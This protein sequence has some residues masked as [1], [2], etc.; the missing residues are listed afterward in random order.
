[1]SEHDNDH[2]SAAARLVAPAWGADGLVVA[3][4]AAPEQPEVHVTP[5]Q[6]NPRAVAVSSDGTRAYTAN[7]DAGTLSVVDLGPAVPAVLRSPSAGKNPCAVTAGLAGD[8]VC[9]ANW[10]DDQVA[11]FDKEGLSSPVT[12][13]VGKGP[14]A[15]AAAPGG[16]AQHVC[17]VNETDATVSLVDVGTS[18]SPSVTATVPV[19]GV[20]RAIAVAKGGRFAYVAS[21]GDGTANG[22]VTVLDVDAEGDP[23]GDPVSVGAEPRALALSA[24]G[25]RL[26][27]AAYGSASVSVASVNPTTGRIETPVSIPVEPHPVAVAFTPDGSLILAVG[28]TS[29]RLTAIRTDTLTPTTLDEPVGAVPAGV[30]PGPDGRFAYVSD[31]ASGTLVTVRTSPRKTVEVRTGA[32]SQPVNV[33]VAPD[34]SWAYAADS[35]SGNVAVLDLGQLQPGTPVPLGGAHKPWDVA[36]APDRT[37]ACATSPGT[38]ALLVLTPAQGE[39][40][41][42]GGAVTVKAIALAPNA[43]PHGVAI[44]PDGHYAVTAD[45]GTATVSLVDPKGGKYTIEAGVVGC[46]QPTGA[47]LSKDGTTLY[48]SDFA[49][50]S[51]NGQ[52]A[53]LTRTSPGT[54]QQ[55]TPIDSVT[56][57][58][59]GPHELGLS[60]DGLR[61]CVA[62]YQ[63][64]TVSVLQRATTGDRWAFHMTVDKPAMFHPYG[65]ALTPDGRTLYVSNAA[66]NNATVEAFDISGNP[67]THQRTIT[68]ENGDSIPPGLALSPDGQYLYAA[69]SKAWLS[70]DAPLGMVYGIRLSGGG[71]AMTPVAASPA[72][73]HVDRPNGI[74]CPDNQTLYVVNQGRRETPVRDAF[75]AVITLDASRLKVQKVEQQALDKD[76]TP[77]SIAI[78]RDDGT[79]CIANATSG[80]VTVFTSNV[81]PVKVGEPATSRPWDVA[82]SDD[83]V[84]A[85]ISD[86]KAATVHCLRLAD[87]EV[88]RVPVRADPMGVA[89]APGGARAYVANHVDNSITVI[90][91]NG[92]QGRPEETATWKHELITKPESVS[93][94]ADGTWLFVTTENSGAVLMLDATTGTPRFTVPAGRALAAGAP[95]PRAATPLV[96]L[97]DTAGAAVSVVNT[98]ALGR[99][100]GTEAALDLRQ[101]VV[102]PAD[103]KGADR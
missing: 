13:D 34:G 24:E 98:T 86:R 41:T 19:P 11:V 84:Y 94:S 99:V 102:V 10:A 83:G 5:V 7:H 9:V 38:A 64:G 48:V 95:D 93:V 100:G 25:D 15:L 53:V 39:V 32:G 28:Q 96:Y 59:S 33:A 42:F 54:W 58:L 3:G 69:V 26:C 45:A 67:A 23:V 90:S 18:G 71:T 66:G 37:F 68:V 43:E 92:T 21:R 44:T 82:V 40:L 1:M 56:G 77:Y 49:S 31:Q 76:D 88:F 20:T 65:L 51:P 91:L 36:I 101:A 87:R 4:L 55:Q 57:H 8:Q 72:A 80:T 22:H 12:V 73:A 60:A 75:L 85:C 62:N 74:V 2:N 27:V 52:I 70:D 29:G 103:L 61:L 97:A 16:Q 79:C 81:T 47:A 17:V 14:C 46:Q 30:V 6:S 63:N 35:A 50:G 78:A 89:C